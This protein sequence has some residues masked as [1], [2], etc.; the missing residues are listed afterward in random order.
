[1]LGCIVGATAWHAS[2]YLRERMITS[3]DEFRAYRAS[4]A[5]NST[6]LHL[7][8]LRKSMGFVENA[9]LLG[10]GTGSIPEQFR[11][12]AVGQTGVA[13]A[14][15][16]NPHNQIFAVAIQLGFVGAALLAAM[17]IAH[18]LLFR[19]GGTDAWF[20]MIVVVDNVVSALFNSH[21]FDFTSGW[22]YVFGVGV[23]G[24]VVL[25]RRD[26]EHDPEKW[27]PVFGKD[28]APPI[29]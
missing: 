14:P 12:A 4:D 22:L 15:S 17:W 24:G 9:P 25:R 10:H 13:S 18:V 21:L 8:F 29:S 11:Q 1:V 5:A 19:G 3:V 7:E 2:T 27:I 6:G 28:H 23:I 16:E 26:L 20:G